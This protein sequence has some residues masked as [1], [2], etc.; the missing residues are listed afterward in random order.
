LI[1]GDAITVSANPAKKQFRRAVDVNPSV[2]VRNRAVIAAA[3]AH[4]GVTGR[5]TSTRS[6]SGIFQKTSCCV[7]GL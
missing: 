6:P 5:L 2:T 7:S 4:E 1:A 3:G